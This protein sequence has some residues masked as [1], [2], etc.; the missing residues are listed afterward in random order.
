MTSGFQRIKAS[1][2]P[3][4]Q[5]AILSWGVTAFAQ[6]IDHDSDEVKGGGEISSGKPNPTDIERSGW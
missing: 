5:G 3:K 6:C 4:P 1:C 2:E